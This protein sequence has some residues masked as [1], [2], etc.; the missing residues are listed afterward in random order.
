MIL[1]GCGLAT[2]HLYLQH[3]FSEASL[4]AAGDALVTRRKTNGGKTVKEKHVTDIL[5]IELQY[6]EH[7]V[8]GKRSKDE[9]AASQARHQDES[10]QNSLH[11]HSNH[12]SDTANTSCASQATTHPVSNCPEDTLYCFSLNGRKQ[13]QLPYVLSRQLEGRSPSTEEQTEQRTH[14]SG[15]VS[16]M[17]D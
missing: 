1:S 6:L 12:S 2:K 16:S 8:E 7:S 3:L 9:V 10:E 13:H 5:R 11:Q 17:C 14:S 15:C 4:A